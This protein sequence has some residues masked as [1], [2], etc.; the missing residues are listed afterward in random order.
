MDLP[1]WAQGIAAVIGVP[2]VLASAIVSF[3]QIRLMKRDRQPIFEPN[4]SAQWIM[5]QYSGV[6][7]VAISID[8]RNPTPRSFIVDQARLDKPS[9]TVLFNPANGKT[10][11]G[12]PLEVGLDCPPG[13]T[14]L[15]LHAI[16]PNLASVN[17]LSI[18]AIFS[19]KSRDIRCKDQAINVAIQRLNKSI[20]EPIRTI[21]S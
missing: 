4:G 10:S 21:D 1:A 11:E 17:S 5:R 9:E 2:S 6:W 15:F 13:V 7:A 14:T 8:V 12:E 19:S 16:G 20:P 18:T 3:M